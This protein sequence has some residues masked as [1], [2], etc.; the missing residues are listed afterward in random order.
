[1]RSRTVLVVED[2]PAIL[3]EAVSLFEDAGVP[4]R[5]F[6]N[7]DDALAY[8]YEHA[9]S[10]SAI[11]TDLQMPG[12]MDGLTLAEVVGR[13]WPSVSVIL[14]SGRVRPMGPLPHNVRFLAKPWLPA[15]VLAEL[16]DAVDAAKALPP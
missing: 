1:V 16:Q 7:A 14:T 9:E 11:F 13:H 15:Q 6:E 4:V 2:D 5:S 8:M 3:I 12:Y 10:V